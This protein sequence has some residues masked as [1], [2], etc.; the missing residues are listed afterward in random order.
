MSDFVHMHLL[1]SRTLSKEAQAVLL[2]RILELHG[3]VS[4][5]CLGRCTF[6]WQCGLTLW[7]TVWDDGS[8]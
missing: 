6:M 5:S 7:R 1:N 3:P 2:W 8:L 4:L